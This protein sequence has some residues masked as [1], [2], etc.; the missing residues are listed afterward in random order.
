MRLLPLPG[1][2]KV[3]AYYV[4][5]TFL[6][7]LTGRYHLF[8]II[9]ASHPVNCRLWERDNGHAYFTLLTRYMCSVGFVC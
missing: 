5:N 2:Y 9:L 8:I 3:A 7:R 1:E 4:I 6:S